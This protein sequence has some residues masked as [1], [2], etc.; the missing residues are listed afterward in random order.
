MTALA[1]FV[2]E[3]DLND[4]FQAAHLSASGRLRKFRRRHSLRYANPSR[5]RNETLAVASKRQS[6][7][8]A[9]QRQVAPF[10]ARCHALCTKYAVLS[11]K[12]VEFVRSA[13]DEAP[14][15]TNFVRRP[16]HYL[17][18]R[19]PWFCVPGTERSERSGQDEE[20]FGAWVRREALF[21]APSVCN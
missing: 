5:P 12:H 3:I 14:C 18:A 2:V 17:F 7:D 6:S 4:C 11:T 21:A 9:R 16:L 19:R 1:R 10:G 20:C 13:M 15:S 8:C